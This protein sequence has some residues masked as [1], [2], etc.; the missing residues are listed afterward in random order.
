MCAVTDHSRGVGDFGHFA[1]KWNNVCEWWM[2]KRYS[3]GKI[4][5]AIRERAGV[6]LYCR[7]SGSCIEKV[8]IRDV[9][10]I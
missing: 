8:H 5:V 1:R 4:P 7:F 6:Y 9:F 10:K 2:K 3:V